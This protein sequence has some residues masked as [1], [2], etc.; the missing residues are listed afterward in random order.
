MYSAAGLGQV[1]ALQP[2]ADNIVATL[3]ATAQVA[4]PVVAD[5]AGTVLTTLL[6]QLCSSKLRLDDVPHS[7]I[8]GSPGGHSSGTACVLVGTHPTSLEHWNTGTLRC[9]QRL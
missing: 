4:S 6:S 3:L 9:L 8:P 1:G 5:T 7:P 2:H